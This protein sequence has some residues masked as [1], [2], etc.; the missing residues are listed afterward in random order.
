[1]KITTPPTRELMACDLQVFSAK[2]KFSSRPLHRHKT[3]DTSQ[4]LPPLPFTYPSSSTSP[5]ATPVPSTKAKAHSG[6]TLLFLR[7]TKKFP[8]LLFPL[9]P[10]HQLNFSSSLIFSLFIPPSADFGGPKAWL[11]PCFNALPRFRDHPICRTIPVPK[12]CTFCHHSHPNFF[13]HVVFHLSSRLPA[14]PQL[15]PSFSNIE[16]QYV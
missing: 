4:E 10:S 1:M 15:L 12:S 9:L 3:L 5:P 13:S 8:S 14:T 7:L 6:Q 16:M 11:T 2:I